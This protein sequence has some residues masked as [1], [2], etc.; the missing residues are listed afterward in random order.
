MHYAGP[1]RLVAQPE[2]HR[3]AHRDHIVGILA[4]MVPAY[5]LALLLLFDWGA[6]PQ[7]RCPPCPPRRRRGRRGRP[8]GHRV[9]LLCGGEP[10]RAR[11]VAARGIP[12]TVLVGV[13]TRSS[14]GNGTGVIVE[15]QRVITNAHVVEG[16]TQIVVVTADN[17]VWEPRCSAGTPSA[18]SP[19]SRSAG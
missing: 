17:H 6:R 12:S 2:S 14:M 7:R 13:R 11:R 19:C 9:A 3:S 5:G 1:A 4:L 8:L 18:T 16:A 10:S 15:G